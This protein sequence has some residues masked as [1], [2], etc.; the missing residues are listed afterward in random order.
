MTFPFPM[1]V[2][3]TRPASVLYQTTV[4][5]AVNAP[6]YS[7]GSVA[8]GTADA[9]RRIIVGVWAGQLG[10]NINQPDS[11]TV[12]GVAATLVV[13]SNTTG[14]AWQQIWIA[15]VPTGTTGTVVLAR[16]GGDMSAAVIHVWAAYNLLS[17]T[18]IDTVP[19]GTIAN[20]SVGNLDTLAGGIA[21]GHSKS[22]SAGTWTISGLTKDAEGTGSGTGASVRWAAAAKSPTLT[23]TLAISFGQAAANFFTAASWR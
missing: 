11:V 19:F 5:G 12:A 21:V 1:F 6:S 4:F 15:A 20:P 9:T 10:A 7:I 16:S 17:D 8:L 23:E 14:T 3:N 13:T 18:A 22:A 2:P